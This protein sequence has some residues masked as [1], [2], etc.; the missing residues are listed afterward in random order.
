MPSTVAK[1][2]VLVLDMNLED[3][4]DEDDED[5]GTSSTKRMKLAQKLVETIVAQQTY[6]H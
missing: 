6:D 1:A 2:R 4:E 3:D 5:L